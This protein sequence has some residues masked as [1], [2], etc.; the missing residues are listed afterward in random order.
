[1]VAAGLDRADVVRLLLARGAD[2]KMAS[3]VADLN[4]L[5]APAEQEGR[6]QGAGRRRP[7]RAPMSPA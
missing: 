1:M 7:R 5:T 2:W 3:S 4:A 6:P